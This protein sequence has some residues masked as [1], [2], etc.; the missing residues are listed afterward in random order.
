MEVDCALDK[1]ADLFLRFPSCYT[2]WQIG[3]MVTSN[4]V[5]HLLAM[6]FD[7]LNDGPESSSSLPMR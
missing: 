4:L 2:S 5:D 6:R 7:V 1:L 3:Y